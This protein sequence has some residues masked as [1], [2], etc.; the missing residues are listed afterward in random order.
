M[1]IVKTDDRSFVRDTRSNAL[2]NTDKSAL[3]RYRKQR[4]EAAR[5]SALHR[6]VDTLRTQVSVLTSLVEQLLA[7]RQSE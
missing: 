1:S 5:T 6:E 3:E 7:E 2:L 4:A